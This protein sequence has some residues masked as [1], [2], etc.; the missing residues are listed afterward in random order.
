MSDRPSPEK[1]RR[2]QL[3]MLAG[4]VLAVVIA[5]MAALTIQDEFL[6]LLVAIGLGGGIGAYF[7]WRGNRAVR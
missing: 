3:W 5:I 6:G 2:A 1:L 7:A 4:F